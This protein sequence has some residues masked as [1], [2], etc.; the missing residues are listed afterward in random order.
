MVAHGICLSLSDLLH[1][2]ISSCIHVAAVIKGILEEALLAIASGS[3]ASYSGKKNVVDG[4][5]QS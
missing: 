5:S 1:L 3:V 2:I 4:N